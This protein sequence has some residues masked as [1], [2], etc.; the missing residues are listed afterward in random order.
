MQRVERA[1]RPPAL[2]SGFNRHGG[3]FHRGYLS[4]TEKVL[5]ILAGKLLG[6]SSRRIAVNRKVE[7]DRR[8]VDRLWRKFAL[9]GELGALPKGRRGHHNANSKLGPYGRLYLRLAV[10]R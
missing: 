1:Y 7:S 3:A 6:W 8:T 5:H 9:T 2:I 4:N 10:I